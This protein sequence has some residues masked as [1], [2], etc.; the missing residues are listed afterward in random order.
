MEITW[1]TEVEGVWGR[2]GDWEGVGDGGRVGDFMI[3]QT[4]FPFYE[5]PLSS[6]ESDDFSKIINFPNGTYCSKNG[7]GFSIKV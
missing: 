6:P 5:I 7:K 2:V 1:R 4:H 3:C